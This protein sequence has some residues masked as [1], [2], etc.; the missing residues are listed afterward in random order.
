MAAN[1]DFRVVISS[2]THAA[3]DVLL[4]NVREQ[5]EFLSKIRNTHPDLFARYFDKRLLEIDLARMTPRGDLPDDVIR[6]V[7]SSTQPSGSPKAVDVI[8]SSR[9]CVV[10]STPS[11]VYG[12][13]KDRWPKDISSNKFIDCVV[14]DEA[15]QMSLPEAMAASLPLR[16][17]G[18]V[19]VV[20]DHRQMPPIVK[21]D[22][23]GEPRRTFK[24]FRAYASLFEALRERNPAMVKFEESFR[25]HHDMAEFLGNEIYIHDGIRFHSN[26]H[27]VIEAF[28]HADDFVAA[29]LK[30]EHPLTVVIHDEHLSLKRNEYEQELIRPVLEALANRDLYAL[31]AKEGLGVV[32]PHTAQRA[33]LLE[34]IACLTEY[35]PQTGEPGAT[36]VDTVE[37][38]QGDERVVIIISATESDREYL[39]VSGKFLLDPRRLTVALSRA[40]RKL[41][42]VAARSIFEVFSSDEETFANAQL[43]KNLLRRTCTVPLWT[44]TREGIGVE[45]WGN[46]S[47]GTPTP[48]D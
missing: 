37:R 24:E 40:K 16:A 29:V 2:K 17:T 30:P 41:V 48:P 15:S 18:S 45:V 19:I 13:I 32:V 42:L 27:D 20:G 22:W 25:L 31:G 43:W 8:Q 21:N 4:T 5:R 6:L 39:L 35:D 14:L 12:M 9:W 10:G 34:Q 28:D 3:I 23:A 46:R 36:A 7:R 11:G 47:T 26:R 1:R 33:G 38:Y 44:G